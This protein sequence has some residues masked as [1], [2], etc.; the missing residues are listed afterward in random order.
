MTKVRNK[1]F[2]KAKKYKATAKITVD[3]ESSSK[4]N[5]QADFGKEYENFEIIHSKFQN[6]LEHR[7]GRN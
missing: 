6:K 7:S 3:I 5:H 4:D 2:L 1:H